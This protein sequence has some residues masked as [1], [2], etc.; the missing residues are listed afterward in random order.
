[1]NFKRVKEIEALRLKV[2]DSL[3]YL[4]KQLIKID[5]LQALFYHT[6]LKE[7]LELCN[8]VIAENEGKAHYARILQIAIFHKIRILSY[9]GEAEKALSLSKS[10]VVFNYEKLTADDRYV[11]NQGLITCC[12]FSND[13]LKAIALSQT[14][15]DNDYDLLNEKN[16]LN[17][18]IGLGESF[19]QLSF[20]DLAMEEFNK[21]LSLLGDHENA[22]LFL[23]IGR[24]FI[25]EKKYDNALENFNKALKIELINEGREA[26]KSVLYEMMARCYA[27]MKEPIKMQQSMQSAKEYARLYNNPLF[28]SITDVVAIDLLNDINE[29]DEAILIGEELLQNKILLKSER[30]YFSVYQTL[31]KSYFNIGNTNKALEYAKIYYNFHKNKGRKSNLKNVY[32][33]LI[34]IYEKNKDLENLVDI[35]KKLIVLSEEINK[36]NE[37]NAIIQFEIKYATAEKEKALVQQKAE[38]I[39]FQLQSLRS[40][41]N[42]HFIFN[43]IGS[44]SAD[45]DKNSIEK[46]R[47]LLQSFSSLMR[48][49]LEFAEQEKISLEE[50]INFLNDYL[51]L[52]AFRL[53]QGLEFE[54]KYDEDLD[55]DFIEIPS[56]IIQAYVENAIKHGITPLKNKGKISITFTETDDALVCII[57]DN[58]VG[59]KQAGVNKIHSISNLG[60]STTINAKRLHLLHSNDDKLVHV[61]YTDLESSSGSSLGTKVEIVIKL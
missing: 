13:Y 21:G 55:I 20:R 11:L 47:V 60:K 16:K 5:L 23:L 57:S 36:E 39:K 37:Q 35:Q 49:N 19:H 22:N 12:K 34:L 8:E 27:A 59:R 42:P 9:M 32:E 38:S 58:G 50:E 24:L 53:N 3:D 28:E 46:S 4:E 25:G 44:I 40:Q 41:M 15:M 1:M 61:K 33:L 6:N 14:I 51:N 7:A 54:I 52:E 17:Y 18:H 31:A 2:D 45:L 43:T 56:M 10:K 29:F 30:F 48:A 26:S